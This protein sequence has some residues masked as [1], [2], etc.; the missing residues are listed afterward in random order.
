MKWMR[1]PRQAHQFV[2]RINLGL[3]EQRIV[4]S[5]DH[6]AMLRRINVMP[7]LVMALEM[8]AGRRDDAEKTLQ[9][10]KRHRSTADAGETRRLATQ[11]LA[12]KLGRHAVRVGGD[13]LAERSRP[14]RVFENVRIALGG[15]N[16]LRRS[17]RGPRGAGREQALAQEIATAGGNV[18]DLRFRQ[19]VFG[20]R[21][22]TPRLLVDFTHMDKPLCLFD[23][24]TAIHRGHAQLV[25]EVAAGDRDADR[26]TDV[27][28][29]RVDDPIE[30]GAAL[31]SPVD[32]TGPEE[33]V[34]VARDVGL[35]QA[36][37]L[38]D[39]M[40]RP[41]IRTQARK[42]AQTGRIGQQ[43]EVMRHLLENL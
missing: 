32:H 43:P 24:S 15:A 20:R 3:L 28:E 13:R 16:H 38:D 12:F 26:S 30:N 17:Q 35:R 6:Q 21:P 41:L 25:T 29:I 7:A 1:E 8:Q 22:Q 27:D 40:H 4:G 9:R 19:E 14:C 36:D 37:F 2:E 39:L 11:Q 5:V 33:N 18:L 31:A 42:N 10:R 34:E 23:V